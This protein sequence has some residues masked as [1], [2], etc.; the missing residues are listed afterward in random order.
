MDD[1]RISIY[2]THTQHTYVRRYVLQF[3]LNCA[4]ADEGTYF[5]AAKSFE[6]GFLYLVSVNSVTFQ[7]IVFVPCVCVYVRM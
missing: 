4:G 3:H 5:K 6:T 1:V 2:S 7:Y